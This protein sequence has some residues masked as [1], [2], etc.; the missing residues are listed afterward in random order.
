MAPFRP[1]LRAVLDHAGDPDLTIRLA[2]YWYLRGKHSEGHRRLSAVRDDAE[3]ALWAQGFALLTGR[4]AADRLPATGTSPRARWFLALAH[5]HLGESVRARELIDGALADFRAAGDQWGTAAALASRTKQALFE[6][7]LALAERSGT[8]S[9]A[10]FTALGDRWG[11]LQAADMLG[12]LAEITGDYERA[13]RLHRDGLRHAEEL[14]LWVDASYRL[15]SLGRIALLTGD[16]DRAEEF[17]ERGLRLAAEQSSPF[18][19]AFARTGLALGG[20]RSGD[21][22]GAERHLR[23]ALAWH[24]RMADEHGTPHYGMTLVLAELGF[25]AEQRGD[26]VHARTWH[27]EGLTVATALGD[28]RAIALAREGLAGAAALAGSAEEA[29]ALLTQAAALRESAGAPLPAAERGDV[30]RIEAR[31]R[32]AVRRPSAGHARPGSG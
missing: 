5:L 27:L 26:A 14:H 32:A 24:R 1:N 17:H 3:A 7:D 4:P 19:V 20:R 25:L 2:W 21:L 15:A 10:L 16:F 6:G 12:Y 13:A 18:A 29:E 28:P 22:D 11:R 23:D 9:L 30:T 8:E 31:I